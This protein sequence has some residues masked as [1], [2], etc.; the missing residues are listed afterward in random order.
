MD[1]TPN[2]RDGPHKSSVTVRISHVKLET[3][4]IKMEKKNYLING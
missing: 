3:S 2:R 1:V 4:N